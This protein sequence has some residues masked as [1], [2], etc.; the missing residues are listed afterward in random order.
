MNSHVGRSLV[1][2]QAALVPTHP[3]LMGDWA[4]LHPDR[5]RTGQ[6]HVPSVL[7]HIPV[8]IGQC[9]CTLGLVSSWPDTCQ[10]DL[11]S[12][13]QSYFWPARKG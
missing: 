5:G 11:A 2:Y 13:A 6:E 4:F 1:R 3:A 7:N 12:V 8:L 10:F 9:C